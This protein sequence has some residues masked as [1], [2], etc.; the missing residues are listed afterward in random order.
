MSNDRVRIGRLSFK[1]RN[2]AKA[3]SILTVWRGSNGGY[4][5]SKDKH[6]D[7]YPAI[8]LFE[9]LKAWGT[10]EGFLDFWPA[11]ASRGGSQPR[12]QGAPQTHAA[13]SGFD[14]WND[15]DPPF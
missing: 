15:A 8:G 6:S 10:G 3:K 1:G 7:Q 2:D 5:I 14:D 4:S 12:A 11:D 13:P 9:A